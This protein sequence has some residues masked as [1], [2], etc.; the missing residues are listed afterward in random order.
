MGFIR[1][2]PEPPPDQNEWL[3]PAV[4]TAL[5][6]FTFAC[7]IFCGWA[8][9]AFEDRLALGHQTSRSLA[10][11]LMLVVL[12]VGWRTWWGARRAIDLYRRARK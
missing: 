10:F 6:A 9:R 4:S 8:F 11:G 2:D 5:G 12:F 3:F 7:L 1:Y